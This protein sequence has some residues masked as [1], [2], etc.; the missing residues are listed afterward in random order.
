MGSKK[1]W[2]RKWY[3]H[4]RDI[5]INRINLWEPVFMNYMLETNLNGTPKIASESYHDFSTYSFYDDKNRNIK[6]YKNYVVRAY[7]KPEIQYRLTKYYR[8]LYENNAP[9]IVGFLAELKL[10]GNE[11]TELIVLQSEDNPLQKR[12]SQTTWN[13]INKE[14]LIDWIKKQTKE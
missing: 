2:T 10:A 6:I 5:R 14:E 11:N 7:I 8:T 1:N 12:N 4:E 3:Q 9:D 13:N